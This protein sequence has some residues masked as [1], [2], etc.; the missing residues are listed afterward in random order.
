MTGVCLGYNANAPVR[1]DAMTRGLE[2]GRN[3]PSAHATG[4]VARAL[5]EEARL[6][7]PARIGVPSPNIVFTG[8]REVNALAIESAVGT[9]S[10]RLIVSA[11][12]PRG[13]LETTTASGATVETLPLGAN[14]V[15]NLGWRKRRLSAWHAAA[16]NSF[17]ALMLA[18]NETGV[19]QPWP[20]PP[21]GSAPA[22]RL[23]R[24][25]STRAP[26]LPP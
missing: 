14:G 2:A 24:T 15:A 23:R 6:D 16:D 11:I 20:W 25:R 5:V 19:V 22:R 17:V 9:G 12:E 26:S 7:V 10:K 3:P 18:D 8:A 1:P 13:G 21:S 4:Q